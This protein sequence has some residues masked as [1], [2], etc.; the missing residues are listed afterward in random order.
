MQDKLLMLDIDGVL[1][2]HNAFP[3]K[4]CGIQF[5]QAVLLDFIVRTTGC[6]III[7]SA[8]RYNMI[9]GGMSLV[10][11]RNM[12][13]SHGVSKEV[14][15]SIID[16]TGRDVDIH[17]PHDRGKLVATYLKKRQHSVAVVLDDLALGYVEN[18]LNF[19]QTKS[20]VGLTLTEATE[21]VALFNGD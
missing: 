17:D 16:Y 9:M 10:G 18:G 1:N 13:L 21:V 20:N 11:F 19:V 14:T 7:I 2:D 6:K 15:D 8:W 5:E 12:L 4:Y 3:N